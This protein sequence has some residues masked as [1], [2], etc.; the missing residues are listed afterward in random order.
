MSILK[1]GGRGGDLRQKRLTRWTFVL[2]YMNGTA[3]ASD[4]E[5]FRGLMGQ[6]WLRG[7]AKCKREQRGGLELSEE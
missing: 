1:K 5:G 3:K 7:D 2:K 4:K 6:G